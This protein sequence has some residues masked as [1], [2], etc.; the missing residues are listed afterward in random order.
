M[1][2]E[3]AVVIEEGVVA[4]WID[5]RGFGFLHLDGSPDL[6][7]PA[8]SARDPT[9]AR[10]SFTAGEPVRFT[11]GTD[12]SGRPVATWVRRIPVA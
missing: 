5:G 3:T 11:R 7:F 6:F 12:R 2:V 10:V 1:G 4:T 8:R 9:G